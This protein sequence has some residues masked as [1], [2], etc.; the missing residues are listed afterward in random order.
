MYTIA[1]LTERI[2]KEEKRFST[3][4]SQRISTT[5]YDTSSLLAEN[6]FAQY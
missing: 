1:E 5:Q 4:Q 3:A 6:A 2:N